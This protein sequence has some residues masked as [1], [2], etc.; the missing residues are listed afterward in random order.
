[1]AP[2]PAPAIHTRAPFVAEWRPRRHPPVDDADAPIRIR[3]RSGDMHR[4]DRNLQGP[5]SGR[6][7][8]RW[9]EA[10]TRQEQL[11]L[12]SSRWRRSSQ[13]YYVP[14]HVE[15][16]PSQRICEA[17]AI[18]LGEGA[19]AGWAAAH[20]QGSPFMDGQAPDGRL[21]PV[22]LC[23]GKE[24]HR[25]RQPG[26][27][28][29]RDRL[30][31]PDIAIVEG[32]RCTTP[33][34]TAFD[35]ARRAPNDTAA[36]AAVDTL[37]ECGLIARGTFDEY[38]N[39]HAGWRG[40][41]RARLA[42][43]LSEYGVR[44]PGETRSRMAWRGAGLPP[45]LVNPAIFSFDGYMIGIGD[46]LSPEASTLVEYDGEDHLSEAQRA[47]D[48]RRDK[49]FAIHGLATVRLTK[50]DLNG[51][52]DALHERL[53]RAYIEG[54]GRPTSDRRWTLDAPPGWDG[55]MPRQDPR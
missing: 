8:V 41:R 21:L 12:K 2:S 27:D 52:R 15:T 1:M 7:P 31:T 11:E 10:F 45:V 32:L 47:S 20:W 50:D 24:S 4:W 28:I 37:L 26:I 30:S 14:T 6:E 33:L 18:L 22:L 55:Q 34:R 23:L 13:G 43:E 44:S 54:R 51:P 29:S 46:L 19:I 9:A 17:H 3:E 35:L 16:S 36:V 38:V 25:H 42:A 48:E 40:V 5:R 49:R 39:A 53:R